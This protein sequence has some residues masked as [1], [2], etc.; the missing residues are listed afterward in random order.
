MSLFIVNE[1]LDTP[2]II[3]AKKILE[4]QSFAHIK[5]GFMTVN[6]FFLLTGKI[7]ESHHLLNEK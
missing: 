5:A 4:V 1:I 6:A 7:L 2:V 3:Q